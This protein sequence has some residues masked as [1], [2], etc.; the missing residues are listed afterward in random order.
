MAATPEEFLGQQ[1]FL[2]RL[3][4][5]SP[6]LFLDL[7]PTPRDDDGHSSFDDMV[8]PYISRLL[9]EEGTEDHLFYLYPNHP[10]V[11]RAQQPFAQILVDLAD[12]A[13]ASGSTSSPSSSSDATASTTPSTATASASASASPDDAPVQ[14]SRPPYTDVNGHASASPDNHSPGLLNGDEMAKRPSSDL[15]NHLLPRD[16]DM[17]NLAFLKGM[18]EASKFLPPDITLSIN[19]GTVVGGGNAVSLNNKKR[20]ALALE[21][22]VG[23]PSKLMMPE[24]EERKMFDEMMF[25]EHEICMKGTQN[26]TA[27]V[28]GEPGKNSRKNGRSRKA[29]DDSEMVDLHTL[30]L[31]CAQALSTDNRQSAIELLKRIRQHSSPKGDAG[32]RLAHYFA[33]GLEARL[34]GRGSELYQSLLLSRISVA[35][36]LKANQLY[37]AA[38]CCKKVAYIFADK[39]ICNAVAGKRRLHIVDYGLNQG[40]QWPGL[41]RMLAAREGGPPE[42]RITGI[43]LPQPGFH[44]AY[45][46]EET[47]RR[48]SNFARVFGVPFKFR[49]IPAK[50]E[51][52]RPEDLN[53][54]R[55][56][57]L[58]V[59]SLCHFRHLMDE[60]LGFDGP[61]PRDQV[62]NNIRKMRPDVFIHGIMNGSYGATSFLTR[63]REA[64][65]HYS[66]QFDLLDT[67]A[68]RD[69]EGRLLLERDIFG[70][71]CLNVLACEGADRVERPETYKQWQL[72]NHRAGLRQLPL[73]PEVV[74]LVLDKVKD[75]YHRNFVVDADQRWLL[76]RWKGRVLYAWSSWI[77]ADAT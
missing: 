21:P 73:N 23:R 40:L 65:F 20:A 53:I 33:N 42:V 9:M 67:T 57:V 64:L 69:N 60:S 70:R 44:G 34:A 52:V 2:A 30:L 47:G 36:F 22:D 16:E 15:F 3:E 4:P 37:T 63:F 62:L 50:R 74:K 46:I 55:D 32:Q 39:T 43:D 19:E 77:A 76:H 61:S 31:N 68:P 51:T 5:P 56:E 75:N 59:I 6:S 71:S 41:L 11:L 24:Q 28:D 1:G 45:H 13:S 35:D 29:V 7:P 17:L 26:L 27:A 54:D 12:S 49:G 8:L 66:A 38:C 14:I 72:R 25:Q 10:A 18:E 48:L 58:V